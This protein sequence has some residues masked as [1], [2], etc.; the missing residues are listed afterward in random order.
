MTW[1]DDALLLAPSMLLR[2]AVAW[3]DGPHPDTFR[4]SFTDAGRTVDAEVLIAADGAPRDVRTDDRWAELPGGAQR[5]RWSTPVD[6]WRLVGGRPRITEAHAV[7]DL[8]GGG[9]QGRV[10]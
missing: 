3:S 6:G 4:V 5:V 2:P 7:W 10:V 1:L 9:D 8:P